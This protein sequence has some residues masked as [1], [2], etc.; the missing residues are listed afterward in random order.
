M[1]ETLKALIQRFTEEI[2]H[3]GHLDKIEEFVAPNYIRHT[4][5]TVGEG[6]DFHGPAG[7]RQAI[8][9][10]RSGFPDAHFTLEDILVDGDKVVVRWTCQGTHQGVFRGIAPTGKRVK[11]TGIAIYRI[12]DGKIVERWAEEDGL[13]LFEQLGGLPPRG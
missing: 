6:R 13:S 5:H 12:T 8:A 3:Q 10:F 1:S 9:V 11:F 4:S 7:F 2:H